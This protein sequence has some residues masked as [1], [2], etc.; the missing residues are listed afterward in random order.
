MST[1]RVLEP[2]RRSCKR[3]R[4]DIRS[5]SEPLGTLS[6]RFK[7]RCHPAAVMHGVHDLRAFV[8]QDA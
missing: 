5:S 7:N 8:R 1:A 3:L 6:H 2:G 4:E